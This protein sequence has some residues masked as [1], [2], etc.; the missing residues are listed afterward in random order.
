VTGNLNPET[1]TVLR[2]TG[3]GVFERDGD[4]YASYNPYALVAADMNND[5]LTDIVAVGED[6]EYM[7]HVAVL[8]GVGEGA[9]DGPSVYTGGSF[10]YDLCVSDFD[11]DGFLDVARSCNDGIAIYTGTVGGYLILSAT[12]PGVSAVALSAADLDRDGDIDLAGAL[13]W[14]DSVAVFLNSD[15]GTFTAA[16]TYFSGVNAVDIITADVVGDDH[17]MDLV[18]VCAADKTVAIL[19][20]GGPATFSAP[21]VIAVPDGPVSATTGDFDG[22]GDLDIV[23][24]NADSGTVS[25]LLNTNNTAI[26]LVLSREV[27]G[28]PSSVA[29]ADLDGDGDLDPAVTDFST[30]GG[31]TVLINQDREYIRGDANDDGNIN[32]GDAVFIINYIFRGGPP[33]N[34]PEAA[35]ANCD[36]NINVGDAVYIISYIF[37]GG[38]PP[39]FP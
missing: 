39:C 10:A 34:H 1:I 32:V 28:N 26:S 36:G 7:A 6:G 12:I 23:T 24:A 27:G 37:R 11:A 13:G 25:Y 2:N 20:N 16:G 29:T 3:A 4:Y 8:P 31:V 17:F 35:E 18:V 9:F 5:D 30:A 15:H 21:E 14:D 19:A 33:P 38:P 22:D